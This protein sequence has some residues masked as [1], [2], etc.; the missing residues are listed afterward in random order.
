M[1]H[2]LLHDINHL[3]PDRHE[4][5]ILHAFLSAYP[6]LASF[7]TILRL[8]AAHDRSVQPHDTFNAVSASSLCQRMQK[9]LAAM[10][11]QQ[12]SR[13]LDDF[14]LIPVATIAPLLQ[15]IRQRHTSDAYLR[16]IAAAISDSPHLKPWCNRPVSR[17]TH[18]RPFTDTQ[19]LHKI[20]MATGSI[21]ATEVLL[22]CMAVAA[23]HTTDTLAT[24]ANATSDTAA[25][26]RRQAL[27]QIA[28]P[29]F[30]LALEADCQALLMGYVALID[31]DEEDPEE[32]VKKQRAGRIF[33]R[34][35]DAH[36][37]AERIRHQHPELL[38]RSYRIML[39]DDMLLQPHAQ[40]SQ[41]ERDQQQAMPTCLS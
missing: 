33:V 4:Q 41:E 14:H 19:A 18:G 29:A 32:G 39:V 17:S 6:P 12:D 11:Q 26:S 27:L 34:A 13:L 30:E 5:A 22:L 23:D 24:M 38:R 21:N 15:A 25:S 20:A 31:A 36:D 28:T 40:E 35:F 37:A 8:L 16:R 3:L 7:E 10:H 2:H 1:Q 9:A